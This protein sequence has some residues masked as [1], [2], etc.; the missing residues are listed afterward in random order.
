MNQEK[1]E[2][3][4]SNVV[5]CHH[6]QNAGLMKIVASYSTVRTFQYEE[7]LERTAGYIYQLLLCLVCEGVTLY[8]ISEDDAQDPPQFEK[9][10]L[11]PP[12]KAH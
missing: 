9:E 11:Y 8:K 1:A 5:M 3:L 6:C 7:G 12:V 2:E 10:V 4:T